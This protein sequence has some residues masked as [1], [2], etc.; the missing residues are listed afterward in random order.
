MYCYNC[1]NEIK[2]GNVCDC[3]KNANNSNA[4]PHHLKP[5][6]ILNGKYLVGNCIGEGGFGITYIGRDLVLDIRVA[7]KEFYPNGYANRN[8]SVTQ[9]VTTTSQSQKNFFDK[10][11]ERFLNEAKNIAKFVGE[12]G[13]VSIREYFEANNTA[14]IIMEYLDG[15]NLSRYIKQNGRMPAKTIFNLMLPIMDSLKRVHDAGIIHR[16]ISPDNIMLMKNGTLKL[17]DF[18][19]AR[20]FA[21]EEK[22][23]SIMLKKGYAPEEQY[24]QHGYQGPWTDVYALC[25]TIYRL[26]TGVTPTDALDRMHQDTLKRSSQLGVTIS[27]ALE[28]VL[29]YGLS[30][31]IEKRYKNMHDLMLGIRKALNNETLPSL[32]TATNH[33]NPH[34]AGGQVIAENINKQSTTNRPPQNIS[35]QQKRE[36]YTPAPEPIK[37]KR[38]SGAAIFGIIV[39]L[40]TLVAM[41]LGFY[42]FVLPMLNPE[43]KSDDTNKKKEISVISTEA[44]T[45]APTEDDSIEVPDV[46]DMSLE[47]ATEKLVDKDLNVTPVYIYSNEV[48]ENHVI[49]Q[50]PAAGTKLEYG[51]EVKLY[52]S[53]KSSNISDEDYISADDMT[54]EEISEE[55]NKIISYYNRNQ[56]I[57]WS[58]V[59][60]GSP[61][62][63]NKP[64]NYKR[65]YMFYNNQLVYGL[66]YNDEE[67]HEYYFKDDKLI[68]YVDAEGY[69]YDRYEFEKNLFDDE[70]LILKESYAALE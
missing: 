36:I 32:N 38:H 11:K 40:V 47:R 29:M 20:Y 35:T 10:G 65:Q 12:P 57:S 44:P 41:G 16:D 43:D 22:E 56:N 55:V 14:Y 30:L 48:A 63:N 66:V 5:G 59:P 54:S 51:D 24:R 25:A 45:K 33:Q 26:I 21:N 8:N 68:R 13:I 52:V 53:V 28:T 62:L 19:S 61:N 6:Q 7:I 39:I 69:R 9:Q 67:S 1:M 34:T 27:P 31:T 64:L 42:Y 3:C 46:T 23:M 70:K 18:G 49:R 4:M 50:H 2:Y 58:Y 17:M 60:S 15:I 37:E